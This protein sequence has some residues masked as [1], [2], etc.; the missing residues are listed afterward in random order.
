MLTTSGP[1]F[2]WHTPSAFS[3]S[4]VVKPSWG[5]LRG[6]LA[7]TTRP[8]SAKADGAKGAKPSRA[9]SRSRWPRSP[10]RRPSSRHLADDRGIATAPRRIDR[11]RASTFFGK[12]GLPELQGKGSFPAKLE[13]TR[14]MSVFSLRW[15]A[16][17]SSCSM[18]PG[19]RRGAIVFTFGPK[20]DSLQRA[21]GQNAQTASERSNRNGVIFPVVGLTSNGR[22]RDD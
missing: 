18:V 12:S 6:A 10:F 19:N 4:G 9:M 3:A 14:G 2:L 5:F 1:D 8:K 21:R 20:S 17:L 7:L 15:R 13:V 11:V 16:E 22:D